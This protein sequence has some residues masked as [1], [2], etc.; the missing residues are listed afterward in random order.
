VGEYKIERLLGEGGFGSVYEAVHP[1]IGKRAAIKAARAAR[2]GRA[3]NRPS[4]S[5]SLPS[6]AR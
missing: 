6:A 3:R 5:H 2:G 4:A 1:L